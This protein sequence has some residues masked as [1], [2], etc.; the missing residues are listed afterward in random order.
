MIGSEGSQGAPT[1]R[2]QDLLTCR[3][4]GLLRGAG[5]QHTGDADRPFAPMVPP[6]AHAFLSLAD[7]DTLPDQRT[8]PRVLVAAIAAVVL[9]AGLPLAVSLQHPLAALSSKV[10][11]AADLDE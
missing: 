9:A 4:S 3:E 10:T 7:D 8:L 6:L 5:G 11:I 1:R 2:R